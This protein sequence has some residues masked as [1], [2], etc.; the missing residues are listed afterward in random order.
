M[1]DIQPYFTV[2]LNGIGTLFL[3]AVFFEY[4][5]LPIL[6]VCRDKKNRPYFCLRCEIRRKDRCII[7]PSSDNEIQKLQSKETDL[8]SFLRSILSLIIF[9]SSQIPSFQL[10]QQ[11]D[12][13]PLDLPEEGTFLP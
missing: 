2:P 7:A 1:P 13:D 10:V 3:D 8:Y 12:V 5:K 9:D 6:F 11:K 4:E